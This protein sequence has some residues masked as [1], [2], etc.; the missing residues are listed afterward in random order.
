MHIDYDVEGIEESLT[1]SVRAS[2]EYGT[3]LREML[4]EAAE[5]GLQIMQKRIPRGKTGY[6]NRHGART[7]Y[8]SA[9]DSLDMGP[10]TYRP[11]SAGG[12]GSYEIE[13]GAI[14]NPPPHIQYFFEGTRGYPFSIATF[15]RRRGYPQSKTSLV[16]GRA[17]NLG[18]I[19]VIWKLGERPRFVTKRRGQ[20]Q[21]Q[22]W[23]HEAYRY[24]SAYLYARIQ[25][26]HP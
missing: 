19:M 21:Q 2:K 18:K 4:R 1:L 22:A 23:F 15:K 26:F 10:I 16:P 14:N 20:K 9:Y 3:Q 24:A 7:D 11:G 12:G 5:I 25:Q 8:K 17:G 6:A 13:V